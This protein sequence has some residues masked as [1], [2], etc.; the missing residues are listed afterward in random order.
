MGLL[1]LLS[2][3][4]SHG[5]T[6]ATEPLCDDPY[7]EHMLR[8]GGYCKLLRESSQWPDDAI[9]SAAKL[10][11]SDMAFV[12][13]GPARLENIAIMDGNSEACGLFEIEE[14][15]FFIDRCA[16]T[17]AQF[18][19]F[20]D[21]ETYR[22]GAFWPIEVQPFVFQFVDSTGL[23]GP[24]GWRDGG[25]PP[26][27]R[28]HPVVGVSWHE[29]NAYATWL[30]K[31]LPTSSQW[32]RAGT[33]WNTEARYPWGTSFEKG[34]ANVHC[35][36][37]G[38]TIPVTA[39]A[40]SSTPN[41]IL[42]LVGNVWEWVDACFSEVEFDGRMVRIDEPLGEI[43]GGAFDTYLTS[44]ATCRFRSGQSLLNRASNVG[45]RCAAAAALLTGIEASESESDSLDG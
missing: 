17:N 29:A 27:K 31:Q 35:S 10:M 13:A 5:K 39:L 15:A 44:Q 11:Q 20:V 18:K 40:E 32:Q 24:A 34:R 8:N 2:K 30:G 41:G 9:A 14:A 7:A 37:N 4:N 45:F 21:A 28:D 6:P 19:R 3:A 1:N 26:E 25:Y 43:R 22:D 16:V 36:G 42:Q 33:W 38:D 12:P 23:P